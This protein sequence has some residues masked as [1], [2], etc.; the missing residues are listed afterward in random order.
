MNNIHSPET[1][2]Y[3]FSDLLCVNNTF[4]ADWG[5]IFLVL[6]AK[7]HQY[8]PEAGSV[9][10]GDLAVTLIESQELAYYTIRTFRMNKVGGAPSW[11]QRSHWSPTRLCVCMCVC[12]CV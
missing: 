10:I 9:T 11:G 4:F 5:L 6:Q 7:C 1:L 2:L 8:W 3:H 12:A